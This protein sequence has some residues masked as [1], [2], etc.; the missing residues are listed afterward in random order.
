MP[1]LGMTPFWIANAVLW[2]FLFCYM[3][4]GAWAAASGRNT[5]HGDPMRLAVAATAILQAGFS[6]RWLIGPSNE[7]SWK[8]LYVLSAA[9]AIYIA[10]LARAYGRGPR[11]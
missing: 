7:A 6:F 4:P 5:R 9:L 3:A 2:S 11:L 8:A 10:Y 1:D